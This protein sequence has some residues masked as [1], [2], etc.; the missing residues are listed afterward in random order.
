MCSCGRSLVGLHHSRNRK[1]AKKAAR[2][3][4]KFQRKLRAG[5]ATYVD[6]KL[7]IDITLQHL[8]LRSAA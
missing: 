8:T 6:G 7:F 1:L 5:Y 2:S 3:A 4:T